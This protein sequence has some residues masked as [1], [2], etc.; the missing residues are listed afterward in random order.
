VTAVISLLHGVAS[1]VSDRPAGRGSRDTYCL[2]EPA[3]DLLTGGMVSELAVGGCVVLR[4][5]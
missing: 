2:T 5:A 4:I 3:H 1:S